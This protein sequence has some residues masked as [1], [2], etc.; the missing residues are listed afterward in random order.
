MDSNNV[1]FI[2]S[3]NKIDTIWIL[4]GFTMNEKTKQLLI[5]NQKLKDLLHIALA[6]VKSIEETGRELYDDQQREAKGER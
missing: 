1:F 3:E 2:S 4:G 6:L 5:D